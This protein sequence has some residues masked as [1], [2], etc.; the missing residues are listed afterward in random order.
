[1]NEEFRIG[2]IFVKYIKIY[3]AK[4]PRVGQILTELCATRVDC[5]GGYE[6]RSEVFQIL[7]PRA[8][9]HGCEFF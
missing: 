2:R 9:R 6:I 8:H 5:L 4:D 3:V 1:M 7:V